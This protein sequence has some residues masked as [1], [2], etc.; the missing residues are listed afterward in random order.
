MDVPTSNTLPK[1]QY[2]SPSIRQVAL[3]DW[4]L[5][6]A[7]RNRLK[8]FAAITVIYLLGFN[9]QWRLEPDSAL[10]LT[11]GRNLAN[12]E[13]FTY[14]DMIHRLAFPGLPRLFAGVFI[15]FHTDKL[16][17]HLILMLLI[18][19]C[20]LGLTY[21]LF[22]LHVGRPTAVL[23]T[24]GVGISRLFY[25][26]CFELLSD[27]PFLLGVMAFLVGYEAVFCR[28][29][30]TDPNR[31]ARVPW[32]DWFFLIGGFSIAVVM[33]PTMWAL[34]VAAFLA[35]VWSAIRGPYRTRPLLVCGA[36][37]IV[38]F[39]FWLK[40]RHVENSL[41]QYEE[42]FNY[43]FS[44]FS[45]LI[46]TMFVEYAPRLFEA[47]LSQALFGT[48]LGPGLNTLAGIAVLGLGVS[49]FWR[50][51]L[52]G[53]WVGMTVVMVLVAI[54]PLDR[55]FLEVLPLLVFGWWTALRWF[56]HR[57]PGKWATAVFAG[58]FLLGGTTNLLRIAEFVIEQHRRPFL[59]YYKEGRFGSI[60]KVAR[61]LEHRVEPDAWV[62]A[63]PKVARILTF[64][65]KRHVIEPTPEYNWVSASYHTVYLLEPLAAPARNWVAA[66]HST[67]G[68]RIGPEIPGRYEP[69][70][71]APWVLRRVIPLVPQTRPSE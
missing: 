67:L 34:C 56:E 44:H 32:Y 28:R 54:K 6:F 51:P 63:P 14:Q 62:I 58:L 30:P 50:R 21:R 61:M 11:I 70:N 17:P 71:P 53:L 18:G 8:L 52:W 46:H 25:R 60:D 68:P 9:G 47:T 3:S 22:L 57:F 26:Y 37:G 27:M 42:N 4:M 1:L 10:Y 69:D 20:T 39:F 2:A 65:S 33:R 59:E 45:T 15:L 66:Q 55:Y 38:V 24:V 48:R 64:L 43:R 41:G 19:F 31:H 36:M 13:G 40:A 23:V 29:D 7:D 16:L 12:G 5:A 35:L 49:L